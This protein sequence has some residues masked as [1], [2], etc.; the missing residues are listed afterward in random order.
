MK[1]EKEDFIKKTAA[2]SAALSF[3]WISYAK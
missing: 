2:G 3:G 1:N